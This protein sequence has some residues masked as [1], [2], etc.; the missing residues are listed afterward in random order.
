MR[1][2]YVKEIEKKLL[3]NFLKSFEVF[4]YLRMEL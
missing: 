2:P 4:L 3:E 1:T